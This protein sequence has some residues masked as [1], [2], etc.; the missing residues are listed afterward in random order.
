MV[1]DY[2]NNFYIPALKNHR[3][4]VNDDYA[5]TKTLSAYLD[6][7]YREWSSIRFVKV[8]SNAR[9]VMQR[10]D[11]LSVNAYIELGA[12]KPEELLVELYHGPISG[13]TH[14][15]E[16]ASRAEMKCTGQEGNCYRF[17]VKIECNSTGMQGRSVRILPKHPG[18]VHPYR[19]GLIK[20]A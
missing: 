14:T 9:P 10:G 6:K 16:Q 2:S 7:L 3:R 17:Q 8:D 1:M 13:Q 5:E 19:N 18:L 15:I 20:W 11:S 12:L 4:M